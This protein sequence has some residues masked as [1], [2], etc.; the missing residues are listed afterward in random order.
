MMLNAKEENR[1]ALASL[2]GIDEEEAAEKL[3]TKVVVTVA[4]PAAAAFASDLSQLIGKTLQVVS[5]DAG[6]DIEI[7]LGGPGSTP[8]TSSTLCTRI[9]GPGT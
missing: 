2:L 9:T 6:P 1:K 3:Q 7:A 8:A 4:A 5:A